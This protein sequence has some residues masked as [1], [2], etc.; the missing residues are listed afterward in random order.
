MFSTVII[1][2]AILACEMTLSTLEENVIELSESVD[3]LDMSTSNQ[4]GSL[5][6]AKNCV[7][8]KGDE[9]SIATIA[10]ASEQSSVSVDY[11]AKAGRSLSIELP[12]IYDIANMSLCL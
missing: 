7:E 10:T 6:K 11:L 8:G 2:I 3:S 12:S 5:S 9:R 4:H 1:G